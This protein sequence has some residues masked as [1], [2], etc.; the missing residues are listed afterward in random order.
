MEQNE[1]TGLLKDML[2]EHHCCFGMSFAHNGIV[3]ND[4]IWEVVKGFDL[5]YQR[6]RRQAEDSGDVG[7]PN[8][9]VHRMEPHPAYSGVAFPVIPL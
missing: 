9:S 7:A 6:A 5:I 4:V 1:T 8:P 3:P 2:K